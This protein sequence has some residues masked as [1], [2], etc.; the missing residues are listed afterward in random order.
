MT[1]GDFFSGPD[2]YDPGVLVE[3]KWE[4]AMSI[5]GS[6]GYRRDIHL[7]HLHT[8]KSLIQKVVTAVSCNGNILINV[9]P[10]KEGTISPIFE[11]R[12]M[13]LGL[14]L[15]ANGEAIYSSKPWKYQNDTLNGKVWYTK[16]KNSV[17][18]MALGWPEDDVLKVAAPK[19]TKLTKI[20]MLGYKGDPLDFRVN[21]QGILEVSFP[22]MSELERRCGYGC[23]W[24]YTLKF[25]NLANPDQKDVERTKI[26][27]EETNQKMQEGEAES[28]EESENEPEM[29]NDNDKVDDSEIQE[30]VDEANDEASNEEVES[31][32]VKPEKKPGDSEVKQ[33]GTEENP[34]SK[35]EEDKNSD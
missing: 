19:V 4:S 7:N 24:A 20:T 30:Q 6:W 8:A 34:E 32:D 2:R 12:L 14:W 22:S 23:Q 15:N 35:K 29:L 25:E 5:D 1:H 31:Q 26:P 13:Q 9:G 3:H 27:T 17:Y 11:E 21:D 18:G 16:K 33:Q 28:N 10:T